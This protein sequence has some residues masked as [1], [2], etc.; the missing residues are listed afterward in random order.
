MKYLNI[1]AI[2]FISSFLTSCSEE[3]E[4]VDFSG[5][6]V[7][8]LNCVGHVHEDNG[9]EARFIITKID[10]DR[11]QLD[12]GD[13]IIF[14]VRQEE[15]TLIIPEQTANEGNGFDEVTLTGD[16]KKT[17]SGINAIFTVSVDDEGESTCDMILDKK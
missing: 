7:G 16:I 11:Y 3:K 8:P 6:Y 5:V 12:L 13:D 10:T 4:L 15:N 14:T 1:I 2:L 9:S 17:E